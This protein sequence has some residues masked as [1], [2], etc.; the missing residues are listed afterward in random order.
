[1]VVDHLDRRRREEQFPHL[2]GFPLLLTVDETA[3]VLNV[4]EM[5][6][7]RLIADGTLP[8]VRVSTVIRVR[9]DDL[10]DFL[11]RRARGGAAPGARER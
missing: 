11:L 10:R 5:T 1:M 2:A 7:R 8:A 3:A 9:D 6:V 4:S